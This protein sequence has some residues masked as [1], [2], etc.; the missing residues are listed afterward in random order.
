MAG[1]ESRKASGFPLFP[2]YAVGYLPII[3]LAPIVV[4][5]PFPGIS[6]PHPRRTLIRCFPKASHRFS[7]FCPEL[8]PVPP[9]ALLVQTHSPAG[10]SRLFPPSSSFAVSPFRFTPGLRQIF[11]QRSGFYPT[12]HAVNC[13]KCASTRITMNILFLGIDSQNVFQPPVV[14]PRR[15]T[16]LLRNALAGTLFQTLANIPACLI[17]IEAS[18][19]AFAI[20]SVS[21]AKLGHKVKYQSACKPLSAAKMMVMAAR[22]S[23]WALMQLTMQSSC[24][25]KPRK[26]AGNIQFYTARGSV[27]S[28]HCYS[29]ARK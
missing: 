12:S 29:P 22:P 19:G 25:Q 15:Q 6:N 3:T 26:S 10:R 16:G 9:V 5:F 28:P 1:A 4:T 2:G 7:R 14:K 23:Q 24:R 8:W 20:G 11:L 13:T 21:S 18:T 17:G 27:L